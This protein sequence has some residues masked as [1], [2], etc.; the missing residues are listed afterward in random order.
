MLGKTNIMTIKDGTA[1][2][3]VE[4]YRW[5]NV[6]IDGI[7]GTFI[8]A[9]FK[10]NILVGITKDGTIAFTVDGDNWET[11]RL[12]LEDQYELN[13]ITWDGSRYIMVGSYISDKTVTFSDGSSEL[14]KDSYTGMI[15]ITECFENFQIIQASDAETECSRYWTVRAANGIYNIHCT[16]YNIRLVMMSTR[17]F[18]I[19]EL[20]GKLEELYEITLHT[21]SRLN[22][23]VLEEYFRTGNVRQVQTSRGSL[24]Y[25]KKYY[26]TAIGYNHDIETTDGHGVYN[27]IKSIESNNTTDIAE[28][29]ECKDSLYYCMKNNKDNYEFGKI[30]GEKEHAVISI[31]TNYL[32]IGGI[33]Y[34]R[35]ELFINNH[36][37]LIVRNGESVSDKTMENLLDITYDFSM[38]FIIKAF[39][40]IYIFG[41]NGNILVSSDEINSEEA[42][43]VKT[44][45]A[46]KALYDAKKYTDQRWEELNV[47]LLEIEAQNN[48]KES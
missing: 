48:S 4:E 19:V 18:K 15:V 14:Y 16:K 5:N 37:M 3:G 41:T 23:T 39:E 25:F 40:Q 46:R 43:A 35:D 26:G 47:R 34:N 44:M 30:I 38:T 11:A 29:F 45:S 24:V 31:N 32:F 36:Q 9:I 22:W 7:T 17:D 2:S 28:I 21:G 1:A 6:V 8:K 42:L 13:D 27:G 12:D 20:R 10:N 33:Y